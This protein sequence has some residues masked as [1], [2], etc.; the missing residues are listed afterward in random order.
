MVLLLKHHSRGLK[1]WA[2]ATPLSDS[3]DSDDAE[4]SGWEDSE[5]EAL[6]PQDAGAEKYEQKKNAFDKIAKSLEGKTVEVTII[7]CPSSR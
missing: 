2:F 4:I 5:N 3:S 6:D 7:F 1:E